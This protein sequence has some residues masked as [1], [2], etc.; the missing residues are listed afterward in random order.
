MQ[1]CL[2]GATGKMGQ[3]VQQAALQRGD[4]CLGAAV[5]GPGDWEQ[6]QAKDCQVIV[7]FSSSAATEQ[8]VNLALQYQLPLVIGATGHTDSQWAQLQNL[9]HHVPVFWSGNFSTGA[10]VHRQLACLAAQLCGGWDIE[11]VEAH[12]RQ[13]K[14]AP[15]GTALMLAQSL[16]DILQ[17]PWQ[18]QGVSAP[19]QVGVHSLRG[20]TEVGEH[21]VYLFGS[22]ERLVITHTASSRLA[23]AH[24]ALQAAKFVIG[25]GPG[26]YT[27]DDLL[28]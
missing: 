12:H 22:G 16:S 3:A 1:I 8:V 17:R 28:E 25:R 9:S 11:V 18:N 4:I 10:H 13:K 20:G 14:D 15:S 5:N 23:F 24:G 6:L 27:M 19:G 7:D 26:L 2:V 21:Q